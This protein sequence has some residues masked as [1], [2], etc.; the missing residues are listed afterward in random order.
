MTQED[1]PALATDPAWWRRACAETAFT[2]W[3][4]GIALAVKA[5]AMWVQAESDAV[6]DLVSGRGDAG[7]EGSR[8]LRDGTL[9]LKGEIGLRHDGGT[10]IHEG[11][12]IGGGPITGYTI[13][14]SGTASLRMAW[15]FGVS[16]SIRMDSGTPGRGL[17]LTVALPVKGGAER[18]RPIAKPQ[19]LDL[20]TEIGYGYP[21][22]T[23]QVR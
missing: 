5:D 9:S 22:R 12:Q 2:G 20:E 23:A 15:G 13:D 1:E 19:A 6:G 8:A 16:G 14:G 3:G 18:L 7:L 10:R 4:F 21:G 11:L 17:S